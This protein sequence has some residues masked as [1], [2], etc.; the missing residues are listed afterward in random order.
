MQQ[1]EQHNKTFL[2]KRKTY[3]KGKPP[4][5]KAPFVVNPSVPFQGAPVPA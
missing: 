4:S 2:S 3:I 1:F 5:F